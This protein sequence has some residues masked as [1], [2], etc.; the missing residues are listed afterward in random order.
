MN[1]QAMPHAPEME[2]AVLGACML[3][4]TAY[5]KV[6]DFLTPE[7]FYQPAHIMIYRAIVAI[8]KM[9][10]EP[11]I[12]S[13]SQ[14]LRSD[15]TLKDAGGPGYVS[16]LTNKISND[17]SVDYHAR[18]LQ[19]KY[20]LRKAILTSDAV[21][22]AAYDDGD[23]F[24]VLDIWERSLN[25]CKATLAP[26]VL[27]TA[28]DEGRNC[29]DGVK[30]TFI[31]FNT[32]EL[33]DRVMFQSGLVHVFAGRTGMGKSILSVEEAWGW[34]NLG[35]VLMFSPEMTK[36]QVTARILARESGVPYDRILFGRM[37]EQEQD[38][39]AATWNRIGDRMA[40]LL[41]DPTS[42][43]T[44]DRQRAVIDKQLEEG[45]VAV[46]ID[47][48]HEMSTG[49]AK[50][51]NDVSGR[52]KVAYCMTQ[53]NEIAKSRNVPIML[54]AQLNRE[55]EARQDRRP[56][57]SDLLWAGEIEQ[58]A[59]VVGLLYRQ[60]Y[61]EAEPPYSDTLEIAIAKNRDG[62]L[63]VCKTPIIPALSRIGSPPLVM[64]RAANQV[65]DDQP[66]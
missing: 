27:E 40:K 61:Y 14:W 21:S 51:D 30:P 59:A 13:V 16:T 47:H 48:L 6:A 12:L 3:Y 36:K 2:Q 43:V 60:G 5:R 31:R 18:V 9:G 29:A 28:A 17:S 10:A 20:I 32:P 63:S 23:C 33:C 45:I 11:N 54:L 50:I 25:T 44:P 37:T 24:D 38:T 52:A 39:V 49:I 58:K 41:I 15:G 26:N 4:V 19:Q 1:E 65:S 66:Y 56:R 62:G 42:A 64:A 57:I 34:T 35:R 7:M 8:D 55:V 53:V 46:V 22:K